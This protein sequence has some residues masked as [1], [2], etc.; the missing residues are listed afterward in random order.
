MK[1]LEIGQRVKVYGGNSGHDKNRIFTNGNVMTVLDRHNKYGCDSYLCELND[2]NEGTVTQYWF[3]RKQLRPLKK[4]EKFSSIDGK[5]YYVNIY[6]AM[7]SNLRDSLEELEEFRDTNCIG[8]LELIAI[9]KH[10]LEGKS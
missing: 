1:P 8:F 10:L 6:P 7:T 9:K 2:L 5:R 4:K 3:H